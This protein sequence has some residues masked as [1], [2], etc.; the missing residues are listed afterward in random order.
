MCRKIENLDGKCSTIFLPKKWGGRLNGIYTAYHVHSDLSLLDSTTKFQAYIDE[1]VRQGMTAL[2]CSEHGN[3]FQWTAKKRACEKAGLKYLHGCEVYLTEALLMPPDPMEVHNKVMEELATVEEDVVPETYIEQRTAELMES[4]QHKVRD[5]YHTVLIAKNEDGVREL[6]DLVSRAYE[7]DHFYYK[8]RIS[9]EEFLATSSNIIK[10]S[11][12]LASPL[13]KLS[14]SHPM[15]ERLVRHYDYLEIQPHLHPDQISFNRHL[16]QLSAKYGIPLIAGTDTHSLDQYKA[17]CRTLLQDSKHIEFGG[18]DEFDLTFRT[19]DK[20]VEDFRAQ[21]AIPEK[22]WMEAIENTNR[23]A[24]S[25]EDFEVDASFKYPILYGDQDKEKLD[26]AIESGLQEKIKSGAV[27]PE[28]VQPFREAIKEEC[29]V[30]DAIGM[31]SFMLFMSEMIRWCKQNSIPVGFSRG[32]VGGSRVA[33]LT[34][35]IDLN[36]ETW[37]TVFSRF[38]NKDRK[39]IGDIDA[40]FAPDDREK[41][42]NYIINRFGQAKTAFILAIGTVQDK[43]VIDEIVRAFSIRWGRTHLH[44][45]K[46]LNAELKELRLSKA[47][48]EKIKALTAKIAELKEEN[49]QIEKSDPWPLSLGDKIKKEMAVDLDAAREEYPEVFYYFD[50]L[51]GVSVSQSMHPAGIVAS[52]I[53]LRDNYGTFSSDGKVILQ[54]DMDEVHETG[55]VKYD[56]LGLKNV[57]IIKDACEMAGIKYPQSHEINWDDQE[58]WT[59]MLR[60][61]VG[62]FEFEGAYA[63]EMLRKYVPHS[64]FDLALVTAAIRPSGASYRAELMAHKPNH[65]PSKLIDDL[66][67]NSNG[68]LCFQEDVLKFLQ[69]VCGFSGSEADNT[70]RAI[71]RKDEARMQEALPKILDG[72]CAMSDQPQAVAEKEAKE[73]LQ[74]IEDASSYMFGQNHAIG[75]SMLG[76]LCAYLRYY[77]PYEFITAYLNNANNDEDIRAGTALAALY[78]IHITPPKFGSSKD[79]YM[80]DKEDH[81][82]SKGVSSFK[83]LNRPVTNALYQLAQQG[84]PKTFM[85]LLVALKGTGIDARQ[86]E[87]LVKIDY[88]SHYGNAKELLRMVDLFVYLKNGEAKSISKSKVEGSEFEAFLNRH[89]SDTNAKGDVLKSYTITDM[90]GLLEELEN[91]VRSFH[92]PDFSFRDKIRFQDEY[93]GYVDLT[94]GKSADRR[95]LYVSEIFPLKGKNG[96]PWGYALTTKSIGSG[97]SSRLTVRAR[98][99]DRLPI[100]KGNVIYAHDV[101]KERDYW[102]LYRYDIS[103]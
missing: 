55:L 19:Y 11:A 26:E 101:G 35:I 52:P 78:D 64:V 20:L 80:F 96:A 97:K 27:T 103:T 89:A 86:R 72:Y 9:F 90:P 41:V 10:T 28:Q 69:Q 43:G 98:T 30:F 46:P 65:N 59:D 76:Y 67:V 54:L 21:D 36:P 71:A 29:E 16:A 13:N 85:E 42:Y 75:Y 83:F 18:E 3:I 99:Y 70:R 68:Y 2:G 91:H 87:I 88:F 61:P 73:F 31:S 32:S 44:D 102:Y 40:D 62:I 53:T 37:H 12:C 6:N 100:Q 66:L 82:I 24:D 49:K 93:L 23:M 39:E 95:R 81:L 94:T 33:Y 57:Q 84:K 34:D 7:A 25:V 74:V 8:P 48:P 14:I 47:D 77:Y 38:A 51:R 15:Y 5:N 79:C 56:I 17:E 63:H 4:G 50:G 60:S 1:A 45:L 58:V 22:L 92:L